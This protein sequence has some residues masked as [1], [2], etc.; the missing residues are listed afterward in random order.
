M[1]VLC[2]L[3]DEKKKVFIP[4]FAQ[5]WVQSYIALDFT[6]QLLFACH[7]HKTKM[8]EEGRWSEEQR[9]EG[10]GHTG[11]FSLIVLFKNVLGEELAGNSFLKVCLFYL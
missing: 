7:F 5:S 4:C 10:S 9:W 6:V 11:S 1:L 8:K 2:E 3:Q